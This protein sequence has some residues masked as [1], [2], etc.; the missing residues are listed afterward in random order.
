MG[1]PADIATCRRE[2]HD[3]LGEIERHLWFAER[4]GQ[5]WLVPGNRPSA[6]DIAL[7]VHIILCEEGGI[8]RM[9]YPA[10][11]RWTDRVRRL[12][13]FVV[14]SGVFPPAPVLV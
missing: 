13:G 2:A 12:D 6:A 4:A 7:F 9:D 5:A 1:V 11:R 14:M 10:V 3:L 8:D